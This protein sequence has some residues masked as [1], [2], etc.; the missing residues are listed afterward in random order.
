[1]EISSRIPGFYKM[2]VEERKRHIIELC[3]LDEATASR[4]LDP[5]SL[6]EE[7][8]DKMIENVIGTFSLP[9]A[10]GLNFKVNEKDYIIPMAVEEPSIV[11][12]ASYIAKIVRE[13]GGFKTEATERIMI[14][15]IQVV[16]C[17]DFEEAEMAI[18][19]EKEMLI[20][21]ANDAYPSLV[22]RG[23]GAVDL[24]VRMLNE[25]E[26]DYSRML[27]VHVYVNTCDAMGANIINTMA[28][29]LA[30]VVEHLTK[31]KVY[32]RILSN[33]ADRCLAKATCTIPAELLASDGFTGEEVRDGI[34]HAYEFAASDPYRAVT[35]NKGIMNGIDPVIIAT[36]NDWRAVE[37]GAHAYAARDGQY[38]SMSKWYTDEDGHL[39]GELEI[40]MSLGIVGGASRVH[41][42]AQVAYQLLKVDSASEL[43]Q[44][45]VAV[46]LAQN[47]GALKALATDGIQKGH[48][49]LHS[50]SVAVAAGA[51]G[52]MVDVISEKLVE[53]QDIRVGY[54]KKLMEEYV[55]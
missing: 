31:G 36:G 1:M 33:Y 45:I 18:N 43:A 3:G 14:G 6:P 30:P 40:P 41:P 12:S 55:E 11:A 15:Q 24:D 53:A 7:T 48:M 38:R 42:M 49:A 37:A 2:S 4:L 5:V 21:A 22:A 29:S 46:G 39:T 52:D 54:A 27:I 51:T 25:G 35:H 20:Q 34:V 17:P 8:A 10:V 47:L 28:E 13:T 26:S 16:G 9:L 50:R 32:L 44:V 19:R 23:G